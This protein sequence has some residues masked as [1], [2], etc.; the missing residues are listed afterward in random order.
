MFPKL[1]FAVLVAA[2]NERLLEGIIYEV[3]CVLEVGVSKYDIEVVLPPV[4]STG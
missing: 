4:F 3:N 1:M 2:L